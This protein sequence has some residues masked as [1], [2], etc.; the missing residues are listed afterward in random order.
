M[1]DLKCG[2]T[3]CKFNRGYCCC[4]REI[5]VNSNTDCK[6]FTP[7]QSQRTESTEMSSEFVKADYS[8][9]TEVSCNADCLFN[10]EGHCVANGITVTNDHG[11]GASC[12]TFV[13]K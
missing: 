13:K 8:V 4:S 5:S 9:D 2:L 11:T 3:N 1:K 7:Q 10:R 12:L 6:T